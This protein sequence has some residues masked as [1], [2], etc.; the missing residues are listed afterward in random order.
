MVSM[1]HKTRSEGKPAGT[2]LQGPAYRWVCTCGLKSAWFSTQE[3]RDT[4][5]KRHRERVR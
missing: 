3:R 1:E 5:A 2:L 4:M